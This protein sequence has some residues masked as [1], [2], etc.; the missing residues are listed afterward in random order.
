MINRYC[1][2]KWLSSNAAGLIALDLLLGGRAGILYVAGFVFA[3][4]MSWLYAWLMGASN[5]SD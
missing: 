5:E 2:P 1:I 4:A 3:A